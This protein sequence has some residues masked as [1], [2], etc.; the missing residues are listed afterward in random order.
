[1]SEERVNA[2]DQLAMMAHAVWQIGGGDRGAVSQI[3][4]LCDSAESGDYAQAL[5]SGLTIYH[6]YC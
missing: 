4:R 2:R 6:K 5:E 3:M 1:M